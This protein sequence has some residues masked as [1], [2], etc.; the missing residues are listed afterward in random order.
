VADHVGSRYCDLGLVSY[1]PPAGVTEAHPVSE[2]AGCCVLPPGH[3]LASREFITPADLAGESFI[4]MAHGD[5]LRAAVD[6]AFAGDDQRLMH[7]ETPYG[8][9]ICSMVSLG[10]GVGIVNPL[11]ARMYRHTDIVVRPFLP[12]VPFVNYLLL[13]RNRP[14]NLLVDRFTERMLEVIATET[15]TLA[16]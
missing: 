16:P 5:G 13:A 6:A 12:R 7:F 15:E 8:A 11:V 10:L 3:R 9:T 4:S 14:A 1:L 2:L